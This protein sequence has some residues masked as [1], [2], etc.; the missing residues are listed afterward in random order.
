M[1]SQAHHALVTC[2]Q[3]FFF[4]Q[5]EEGEKTYA[6]KHMSWTLKNFAIIF[7]KNSKVENCPKIMVGLLLTFFYYS[8]GISVFPWKCIK[9][10][11]PKFL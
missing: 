3:A 4:R 1:F 11:E 6:I 10:V 2:D 5:T 8:Y 9:T 7:L